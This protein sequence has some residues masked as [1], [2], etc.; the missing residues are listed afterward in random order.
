M[1]FFI[2][3]FFLLSIIFSEKIDSSQGDTDTR[4]LQSND[5]YSNIRIHVDDYCLGLEEDS[6]SK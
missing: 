5:G 1:S 2:F 3:L 4:K 6:S